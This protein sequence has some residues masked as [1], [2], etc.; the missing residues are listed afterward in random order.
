MGNV[1]VDRKRLGASS[2]PSAFPVALSLA[3]PALVQ[4]DIGRHGAGLTNRAERDEG[5]EES[6]EG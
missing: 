1:V 4:G 5:G 2:L 6:E 3:Q